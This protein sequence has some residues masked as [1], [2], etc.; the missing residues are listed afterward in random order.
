MPGSAPVGASIAW[1]AGAG[2]NRRGCT[3]SRWRLRPPAG[4]AGS[5]PPDPVPSLSGP[6]RGAGGGCA[7]APSSGCSPG[8]ITLNRA[9]NC[10]PPTWAARSAMRSATP[11][12][13]GGQLSGTLTRRLSGRSAAVAVVLA[14]LLT[15]GCG[16]D[17][18]R[19]LP[20][21]PTRTPPVPPAGADVRSDVLG[22]VRLRHL[23]RPAARHHVDPG[24]DA[25]R[26]DRDHGR[27]R[28]LHAR[29]GR[30]DRGRVPRRGRLANRAAA[31]R[32]DRRLHR[33][34]G[35]GAAAR[36][37][38]RQLDH[39]GARRRRRRR[40]RHRHPR[41]A[42]RAHLASPSAARSPCV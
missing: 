18:D 21:S 22:P 17:F 13:L 16:D 37:G 11:S 8:R 33:G 5:P 40:L 9:R 25:G 31:V 36:E 10:P 12:Q 30:R 42:A 24:S 7:A 14:V 4:A 6:L 20:T 3:A 41:E 27:H 2:D 35:P 29:D 28:L 26:P 1:N 19:N 39:R 32:R 38:G 34:P 23:R 15:G